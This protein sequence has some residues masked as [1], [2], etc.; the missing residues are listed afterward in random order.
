[1][2]NPMASNACIK[3]LQKEYQALLKDPVPHI[4]AHPS[5][6]NLL[7]W[8]YVLEGTQ[9]TPYE[10]GV[11]YGVLTF[12][13]NYPYNPPSISM[14]T[15]NGRFS[16]GKMICLTMSNF[17][18]ETWNPM[19]SV[20][21]ILLGLLSFM[22]DDV[23]TSGSVMTTYQEKRRLAKASLDFNCNYYDGYFRMLFPEYVIVENDKVEV[24]Q[25]VVVENDKVDDAPKKKVGDKK[26]K[27]GLFGNI[28]QCLR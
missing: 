26:R 28:L 6:I 15:P 24:K 21:S 14:T 9:G 27:G 16:P 8:H 7:Q 13:P 4:K 3:R 19:W 18:P 25:N 5:P 2:V 10:G 17:H 23:G 1:M 22:N 11:Y 20:S 12:P